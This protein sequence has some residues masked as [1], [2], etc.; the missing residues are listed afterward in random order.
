MEGTYQIH[1]NFLFLENKIFRDMDQIKQL[2]IYPPEKGICNLIV[3]YEVPDPEELP[4]NGHE[5]AIDLGLHNLMTCYDSGNGKTFILGRKYLEI[6][7]YFQKENTSS[8]AGTEEF[9][10]VLLYLLTSKTS[11]WQPV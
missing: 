2:R 11:G 8:L 9:V 1:E 7:R 4:Q 3:V 6:E 5:L 10:P